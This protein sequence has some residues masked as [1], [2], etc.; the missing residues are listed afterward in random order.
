MT[1]CKR[2]QQ[3][4]RGHRRE[5]NHLSLNSDLGRHGILFL[6][7]RGQAVCIRFLKRVGSYG[8]GFKFRRLLDSSLH[9]TM[10]STQLSG[11]SAFP[12]CLSRDTLPQSGEYGQEKIGESTSQ[13][14]ALLSSFFKFCFLVFVISCWL[15]S[16]FYEGISKSVFPGSN[17]VPIF[18][19]SSALLTLLML[20]FF[21]VCNSH[22]YEIFFLLCKAI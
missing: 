16:I 9:P 2:S 7:L 19:L 8:G 15:F 18:S 4:Q 11:L 6:L 13:T 3:S 5:A 10:S 12:T 21:S 17:D 14:H 1:G 22:C 20:L